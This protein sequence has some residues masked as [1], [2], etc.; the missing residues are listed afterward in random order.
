MFQECFKSYHVGSTYCNQIRADLDSEPNT[1][2][3]DSSEQALR[4]AGSMPLL[5]FLPFPSFLSLSPISVW[6]RK[7]GTEHYSFFLSQ[8][9]HNKNTNT[10]ALGWLSH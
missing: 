10:G 5:S 6:Q 1:G 4:M 3:L 9:L 7:G 2:V 8:N